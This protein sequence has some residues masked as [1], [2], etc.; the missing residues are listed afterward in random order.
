MRFLGRSLVGVVLASVTLAL[1]AWA[2]LLINGA[3]Q[4]RISAEPRVAPVR[5]RVF[6]VNVIQAELGTQ[7]P[8]LETFGEVQSRRT[9]EL[10]SAAGGRVIA[11]AEAFEDGGKVTAGQ[12]L[13]RIDPA[14]AQS[15][16]Q[17]VQADIADAQADARDAQKAVI[18][19]RDEQAA[20]Q[21]Q[22]ELRQRAFQRQ[23]D[24]LARGAG[25][26]SAV[27]VAELAMSSAKQAVLS[28]RQAVTTAEARIDQSATRLA[29][30]RLALAEAQRRLDETTVFAPFDGTL[31]ATNVVEGRLVN[32]NERLA[33][34]IDADALEVSFRVSTAQ[35]ARLLDSD[36]GLLSADVTVVLDVSGVDL[37]ATGR[38]TRASAGAGEGQSGRLIFARMDSAVGFKPGDFVT[39]QVREPALENVARLPASALGASNEV[40][41]LVDGDR[42]E[43]LT[44]KL[45]RRQGDDVLV[46]GAGLAGREVV[47]ARS[48]LLGAGIAVKPLRG[49]A[50]VPAPP[51]MLELSAER[52]AK[53]VAFVEGNT[54]MPEAAK[55]RVL[56]RLA[57][58]TVPA[59][60]VERIESRMGG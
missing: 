50:V 60:M 31:S 4:A 2:Y 17:S 27:E 40:L 39:V 56:A 58:P 33:D 5:E 49:E 52:R 57:E 32:S 37:S 34:L 3:V 19:A 44:V 28:R 10:R 22:V 41:V 25:T 20:A 9:L 1:M 13:V 12:E 35:Y 42:L 54:R 46:R 47:E 21:E 14:D 36:G 6:T 53:L 7:T 11:L 30:A 38:L 59:Q 26:S 48:P 16:L 23:Q 8:I 43:A 18:L 55:A 45:V 29:R 51:A 15:T 24:L